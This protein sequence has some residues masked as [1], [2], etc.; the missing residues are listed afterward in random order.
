MKVKVLFNEELSKSFL[1][2]FDIINQGHLENFLSS[3][4]MHKIFEDNRDKSK[5]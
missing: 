2:W 4:N 5:E 3:H 1:R